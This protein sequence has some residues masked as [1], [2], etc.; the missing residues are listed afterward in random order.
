VAGTEPQIGLLFES[1]LGDKSVASTEYNTVS[2]S[3]TTLVKVDTGEG[4]TFEQ[5]EALLIKSS[6]NGYDIR[7]ISSISSDDLTINFALGSAPASGVNLGKAVLYK[8][9]ASGHPTFSAWLY[10]GNGFAVQAAAGCT[11]NE[12][13]VSA[14]ATQFINASFSYEGSKYYFNPIEI[15]ASTD[16][17]D[18]TDDSGTWAATVE[19]KWYY[20]PIELASAL[21]SAMNAATSEVF[22][23][24]YSNSTGKFTITYASPT[25]LSLLW[26]TGAN[27]AQTI[28]AKLGFSVAAD[29][30]GA[31]TYTS[32]NA[33]TLTASYTPSY[34]AV[35]PIVF[36][37]AELF[38]GTQLQNWCYCASNV[39]VNISKETEKVLCSCN[40]TGIE[41][42][43][44]V[45]REVTLSATIVLEKYE[46]ASFNHLLNNTTIQAM[47]NVGPK[48]S[49]GN[50]VAGKCVNV[51]FKNSTVVS[52]SVPSGESFITM[53]IEVKGFVS[54]SNGSDVYINFV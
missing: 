5:G 41:E 19:S 32:D 25:T 12:L 4:S 37:D 54:A 35:D 49:S 48:D 53:D 17:I 3:T 42:I 24:S 2:S 28:G 44:A 26:N 50:W 43:I 9:A 33:L 46:V 47:L 30:T 39:E 18:W 27:T 7:N 29:D 6:A 21:Q 10:N 52:R 1:I 38:I 40:E 8:P 22:T 36:K 13:S 31:T 15:T 16:T 51:Y 20:D 23:V 45:G 34:D 14:D 11:V